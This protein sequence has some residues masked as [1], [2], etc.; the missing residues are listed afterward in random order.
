MQWGTGVLEKTK[1]YEY[2][3]ASYRSPQVRLGGDQSSVGACPDLATALT[4]E[5]RGD[6]LPVRGAAL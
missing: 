4:E 5:G 6:T 1:E 2:A 3:E